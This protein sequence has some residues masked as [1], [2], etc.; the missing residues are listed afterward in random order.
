[1]FY[2]TSK[3]ADD[4]IEEDLSYFDLTTYLIGIE[5]V[6]GRIEFFARE[7]CVISGAEEVEKIFENL[8]IKIVKKC[9]S[10]ARIKKGELI[11]SGEGESEKLHKAWKVSANIFEYASYIF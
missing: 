2:T 11:F 10:G 3:E 6:N 8:S 5:G 7:D 9:K 1:M 4:Y